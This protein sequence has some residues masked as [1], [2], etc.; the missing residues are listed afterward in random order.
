MWMTATGTLAHPHTVMASHNKE[1]SNINSLL[2]GWVY[3]DA[4]LERVDDVNRAAVGGGHD[5]HAVRRRLNQGETKGLLRAVVCVVRS[6]K[7]A[8]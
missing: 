3:Q 7:L 4:V 1:H 6:E 8:V 5:G 2:I